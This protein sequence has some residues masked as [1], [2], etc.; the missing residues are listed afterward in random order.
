MA[1]HSAQPRVSVIIVVKDGE[2]YLAHAIESVL[3]QTTS[4][5]E[6]IVIDGQST[7]N[8]AFIAQSFTQVRY[9]RQSNQGLANARNTGIEAACGELIAFLD[10]DDI[11]TAD[12]LHTHVEYMVRNPIPRYTTSLLQF[13]VEEGAK[14]R[15]VG[16]DGAYEAP[17]DGCTPSALVAWRD[18]F[19]E[20]GGFDPAYAVGCDA[21]WFTRARDHAIETAQL[22]RVLVYKRLHSANLSV[23]TALNRQEMFLVA[24]QS[25]A[26]RQRLGHG[27]D[28]AH[29]R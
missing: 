9:V 16:E 3:A 12:K 23:N 26:R 14:R 2:R 24:R 7:D 27:Q 21:D 11:W 1:Q 19:G 13:M 29:H 18:V 22:P 15:T 25:I 10:H 17:R 6:I 20:I 4:P 28:S 8:T 5:C